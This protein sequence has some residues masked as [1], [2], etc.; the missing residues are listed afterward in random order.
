[1]I[2]RLSIKKVIT[3]VF[4]VACVGLFNDTA[5]GRPPLGCMAGLYNRMLPSERFLSPFHGLVLVESGA[6]CNYHRFGLPAHATI[7]LI[8]LLFSNENKSGEYVV[9][10]LNA[11]GDVGHLLDPR[12]IGSLL[13]EIRALRT[14][15]ISTRIFRNVAFPEAVHEKLQAF[16]NLFLEALDECGFFRGVDGLYPRYTPFF[17]LLAFLYESVHGV[18]EYARYFSQFDHPIINEH[19]SGAVAFDYEQFVFKQIQFKRPCFLPTFY[20]DKAAVTVPGHPEFPDCV[21]TATL[22]F[23]CLVMTKLGCYDPISRRYIVDPDVIA[24]KLLAYFEHNASGGVR[25]SNREISREAVLEGLRR[26]IVPVFTVIND[27]P[28]NMQRIHDTWAKTVAHFQDVIYNNPE[29]YELVALP[30]NYL[31][32]TH[33]FLGIK[34]P[35]FADACQFFQIYFLRSSAEQIPSLLAVNDR[36]VLAVGKLVELTLVVNV[37]FV[38]ID[39]PVFVSLFMSGGHGEFNIQRSP[40]PSVDKDIKNEFFEVP[41]SSSPQTRSV[42]LNALSFW[43][44]CNEELDGL[45]PAKIQQKF[46]SAEL[47]HVFLSGDYDGFFYVTSLLKYMLREIRGVSVPGCIW[48]IFDELKRK[49]IRLFNAFAHEYLSDENMLNRI[50]PEVAT[51]LLRDPVLH[52]DG[53]YFFA[54]GDTMLHVALKGGFKSVIILMLDRLRPIDPLVLQRRNILGQTPLHVAASAGPELLKLVVDA[55]VDKK[56]LKST[57]QHDKDFEER[58]PLDYLLP[59]QRAPFLSAIE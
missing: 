23:F 51:N 19:S 2:T 16:I 28:F 50:Y 12:V 7:R 45:M 39:H 15:I 31:A 6:L 41:R 35:T 56:A 49:D 47:Q 58:T 14:P 40:D 21:E 29:G 26:F 42:H 13:N 17:V 59:F 43:G 1:M 11:P 9:R 52:F 46:V 8:K 4:F 3:A 33:H 20:R 30:S 37:P 10:C 36:A 32:L 57:L 5:Y 22:N 53:A 38:D 48:V 25:E 44:K 24:D 27:N 55:C 54:T 18:E 34:L